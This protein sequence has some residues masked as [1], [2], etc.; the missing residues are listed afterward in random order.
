MLKA[1]L[2]CKIFTQFNTQKCRAISP[3]IINYK[4]CKAG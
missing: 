3:Y 1:S 2:N 4:N